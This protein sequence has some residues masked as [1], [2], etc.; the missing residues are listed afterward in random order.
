M[1]RHLERAPELGKVRY[2]RA[3]DERSP[4]TF[5]NPWMLYVNAGFGVGFDSFVYLPSREYP[6]EILGGSTER[7]GSWAYVH[8]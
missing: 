7:V 5:G 1:P 2:V 8:E 4:S 6:D 3:G